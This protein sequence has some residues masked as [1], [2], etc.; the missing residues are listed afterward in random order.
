MSMTICEDRHEPVVYEDYDYRTKKANPCPVCEV[1][2]REAVLQEE[3][4][5]LTHAVG[6]LEDDIEELQK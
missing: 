4:D 1:L 6:V 5:T 3:K 2:D